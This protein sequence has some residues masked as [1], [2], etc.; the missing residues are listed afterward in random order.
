MPSQLCVVLQPVH[1]GCASVGQVA[2][3]ASREGENP[4]KIIFDIN[5]SGVSVDP[6]SEST[7][8]GFAFH[9]ILSSSSSGSNRSF[10]LM[11]SFYDNTAHTVLLYV[12]FCLTHM[13]RNRYTHT[14]TSHVFPV[15]PV[16][17][18]SSTYVLS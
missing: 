8:N 4:L 6:S 3:V 5:S 1:L 7:S 14:V 13:Y 12:L 15:S 18:S 17:V 9:S 16:E 10:F 2:G 11:S